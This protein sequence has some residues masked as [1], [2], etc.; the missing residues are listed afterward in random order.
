MRKTTVL[1]VDDDPAMREVLSLLMEEWDFTARVAS[2]GREGA[3]I[4]ESWEPDIVISDVAMPGYIGLELLRILKKGNAA[5][6][7]F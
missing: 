4:A 6:R 5:R 3:E 2:D 7:S 1:I